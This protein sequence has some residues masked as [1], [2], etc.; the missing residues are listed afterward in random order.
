MA[1]ERCGAYAPLRTVRI[2]ALTAMI[3]GIAQKDWLRHPFDRDVTHWASIS[4]SVCE[5]EAAIP[6]DELMLFL[7]GHHAATFAT[8]D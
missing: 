8:T 7:C 2:L 3:I 1:F 6:A 4:A 5:L